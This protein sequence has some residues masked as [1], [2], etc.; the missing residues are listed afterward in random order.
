MVVMIMDMELIVIITTTTVSCITNIIR[1]TP[2][3]NII[4]HAIINLT[5]IVTMT[6]SSMISIVIIIINIIMSVTIH[7][8]N[9]S[10]SC[11]ALPASEPA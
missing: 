8:S 5:T 2:T 1:F 10:S 3:A 11:S 7:F 4:D 9:R 6:L